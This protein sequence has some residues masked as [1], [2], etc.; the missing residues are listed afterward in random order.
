LVLTKPQINIR[1]IKGK[2]GRIKI[3]EEKYPNINF[4]D[5]IKNNKQI[6]ETIWG[7]NKNIELLRKKQFQNITER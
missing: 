4:I 7:K 3:K 1:N 5:N 6:D 2:F